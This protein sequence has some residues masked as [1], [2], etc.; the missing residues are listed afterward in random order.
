MQIVDMIF[1]RP[2]IE[3]CYLGIAN[4]CFEILENRPDL[5][6]DRDS[7]PD[8]VHGAES[9]ED[10]E[11]LSEDEDGD[12]D[13]DEDEE[14][15]DEDA[16]ENDVE[17]VEG[18]DGAEPVGGSAAE[19]LEQMSPGAY[20]ASEAES[21][22]EESEAGSLDDKHN[23]LNLKLREILYYDDKVAIFRARHMKL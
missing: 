19:G 2:E 18:A 15:D 17:E 21:S 10:G 1:L 12:D 9:E 7:G 13:E 5:D 4:K 16:D 6:R 23:K 20:A 8:A 3:L 22:D 11:A 14:N